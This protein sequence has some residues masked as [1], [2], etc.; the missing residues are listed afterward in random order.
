MPLPLPATLDRFLLE[1]AASLDADATQAAALLPA[2][3]ASG[4]LKRGVPPAL[5]GDGGSTVDAVDAITAVAERSLAAAFV[6]WGQRAFIEYLLQSPN[7]ALR[8]QWL[9]ALLDGLVAGA[10]GLSN[11]MKFLSG[12]ESLQVQA[13]TLARDPSP[14]RFLLDGQVPWA[15]NLRPQGF[16]VAVAVERRDGGAPLVAAVPHDR[17]GLRRSEDLDLIG[18]RGTH[19]AALRL[20][21]VDLGQEDVLAPDARQWLPRVRPAFLGLQ[22]ALAIGMAHAA[23][24][25]AQQHGAAARQVLDAPLRRTRADLDLDKAALREGLSTDRYATDPVPLFE[26]RIRLVH[27]ALQAVQL[28]LQACGGRAYHRDQPI[29]F[30]R[31][32]RE[33][34]FLPIVTPSLTQLQSELDQ[35]AR[36]AE[37]A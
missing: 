30:A 16:L 10:T 18:L 23:L 2:L 20:T 31:R 13:T 29:G 19:T 7:E 25:A 21:R 8:A 11:A 15:T 5:G 36:Q 33:A 6:F 35:R 34:A 17:A 12:I 14:A 3:G 27:L 28:E 24:D 37:D 4:L 32:W 1:H 26:L 22:C 9:P